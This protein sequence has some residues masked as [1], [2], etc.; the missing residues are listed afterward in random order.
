MKPEARVFEIFLVEKDH[1]G[2]WSPEK[3]C[4]F[5]T[6]VSTVCAEAKSE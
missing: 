2:D 6:D 5:G 1:L 4:C 3:T